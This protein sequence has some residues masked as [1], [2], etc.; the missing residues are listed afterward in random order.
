MYIPLRTFSSS[1]IFFY[2]IICKSTVNINLRHSSDCSSNCG[3]FVT[4]IYKRVVARK[5]RLTRRFSFI[6]F[7]EINKINMLMEI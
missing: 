3:V 7:I 2:F 1:R 6:S 4:V 5:I